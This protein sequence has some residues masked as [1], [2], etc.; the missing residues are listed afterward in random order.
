[1]DGDFIVGLIIVAVIGWLVYDNL[2][3]SHYSIIYTLRDSDGSAKFIYDEEYKAE[4]DCI[5]KSTYLNDRGDLFVYQCGYKCRIDGG[6][7]YCDRWI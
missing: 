6:S 1:M 3:A 7:V 4:T 2:I 5:S